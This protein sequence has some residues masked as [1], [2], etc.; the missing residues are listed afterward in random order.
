MPQLLAE[1]LRENPDHLEA[2]YNQAILKLRTSR[3]SMLP[4][5]SALEKAAVSP[6]HVWRRAR[7]LA[8][9]WAAEN[10]LKEAR[11]ILA[12]AGDEP[13]SPSE[14]AEHQHIL[15]NLHVATQSPPFALAPLRSASEL[16]AEAARFRRLLPK[17]RAAMAGNRLNG[18]QRCHLM[19]GVLPGHAAHP[20][21][22][23]RRQRCGRA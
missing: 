3:L 11:G 21:V 9:A 19:L 17:A 4:T 1:A 20:E 8:W 18:A 22:T 15:A 23:A 2:R 13:L 5:V 7:L 16:A 6:A 10:R 12:K 14:S